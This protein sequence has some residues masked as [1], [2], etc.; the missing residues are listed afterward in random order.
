MNYYDELRKE[1]YEPT[2]NKEI[3]ELINIAQT[4]YNK[5]TQQWEE[6]A[7]DARNEIVRRNLRLVSSVVKKYVDGNNH[8]FM[9]CINSCYF[10]I[11]NCIINYNLDGKV[12]FSTYAEVSLQRHI[13]KFIR[14][15]SFSVKF[16]RKQFEKYKND[17][18]SFND[19]ESD[20]K[21]EVFLETIPEK[22]DFINNI[23]KM[24]IKEELKSA[25]NNLPKREKKIIQIRYLQEQKMTLNDVSEIIGLS[26]ERV[27]QIEKKALKKLNGALSQ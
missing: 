12:K 25:I 3:K 5:K 6:K 13:W 14:E 8:L 22:N 7:V 27:R 11:V 17:V 1:N 18:E 20:F 19:E 16:N 2:N 4:G 10:S 15:N 23:F 26:G 21:Q 24:E 9:D